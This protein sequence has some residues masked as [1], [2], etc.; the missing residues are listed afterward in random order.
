MKYGNVS[1]IE[2]PIARLV[3]G[4]MLVRSDSDFKLLDEVIEMGC[5]TFDTAHG[6]A[7]GDSERTIGRWMSTRKNRDKVVIVTKGAH[8]NQDRRRVTPFDI[9]SDLFDSL[10]RL[11]TDYIDLYFLHRDDPAVAVGPII[12]VLNEHLQAGRIKAFG[13]SNWSH[14][15]LQEANDYAKAHGLAGFTASSPQYSL[16]EQIKEPWPNC[17]SIS[18]SAGAEARQWY[19]DTNMP[20]FSWSSL[21]GGFLSGRFNRNNLDSAATDLEKLAI[22]CYGS[23]DNLKRLERATQLASEKQLS[24]PQIALSFVVNQPLNLYAIVGADTGDRYNENLTAYNVMLSADELRW[25][26]L[27][28]ESY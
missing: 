23:E 22:E 10:A 9:S 2:K 5:N 3:L 28:Q 15:R 20:V 6:Y 18:G 8:H 25:L 4:T 1:G 17:I 11:E 26:N 16:A 21:A 13:G 14:T 27:E 7:H 12:D 19:L 24:V